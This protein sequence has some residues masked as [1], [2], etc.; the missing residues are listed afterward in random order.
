[1]LEEIKDELEKVSEIT[2][3]EILTHEYKNENCPPLR[4]PGFTVSF[5]PAG[6]AASVV[7][8]Y[9]GTRHWGD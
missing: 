8:F 2:N 3:V 6:H 9:N 5:A 1:M 4:G 7:A